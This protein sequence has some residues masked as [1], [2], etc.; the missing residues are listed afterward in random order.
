VRVVLPVRGKI[1][2]PRWDVCRGLSLAFGRRF[3]RTLP[4]FQHMFP[5]RLLSKRRLFQLLALLAATVSLPKSFVTAHQ[6]DPTPKPASATIE[7]IATDKR[8]K[9][10]AEGLVADD[11]EVL[12][13][14]LKVQIHLVG[15]TSESALRPLSFWFVVQ[16][17]EEHSY[18]NWVSNGS[19]F[20]RGKTGTLQPILQA[21]HP[22]DTVGVAHWCDDGK[23]GVDLLPTSD[24][25]APVKALDTVL[26]APAVSIGT[27][28]GGDALHDMVLR[29]RDVTQR[30]TPG[31]VPVLIFFYG[32]HSGMFHKEVEDMLEQPVGQLPIVYG[33]NNGAVSVQRLP[34]TNEYT[35]MYVVHFLSE[36]TGGQVLSSFRGDYAAEFDHIVHELYGRYE[37]GI[38]AQG[39]NGKH[40][41]IVVRLSEAARKKSGAI[42]LRF[43]ASYISTSQAPQS[44]EMLTA[45]ALLQAIK[46]NTPYTEIP[47][48]AS[49]KYS[50]VD[51]STQ[52]RLFIDPNSLSWSDSEGGARKA[53][54]AVAIAGLTSDGGVVGTQVKQFDAMQ[55]EADRAAKKAVIFGASYTV[56]QSVIRVRFILRDATS[57]H[58]GSFELPVERIG[59]RAPVNPSSPSG[60][61]KPR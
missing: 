2:E 10:P 22:V 42:D 57:A 54:L 8:T 21:L 43:P 55:S 44:P 29:V 35:Q 4:G 51:S 1:R 33:I 23:L 52:F 13:D 45:A 46:A 49:A 16:C 28:A 38:A 25:S 27:I 53:L 14:R 12:S 39:E 36:K 34:V 61:E 59:G 56:P 18:Y 48:D 58:L 3:Q 32:D 41:E 11:F 47:F 19:G 9:L 40:H 5:T 6:Q 20:I 37:L 60:S 26:S 15:G 24:R 17:P 50:T 31:A 7:V 30:I